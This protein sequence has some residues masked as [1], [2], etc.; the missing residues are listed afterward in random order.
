L[1]FVTDVTILQIMA[2]KKTTYG[3]LFPVGIRWTDTMKGFNGTPK[4]TKTKPAGS[5]RVKPMPAGGDTMKK[6]KGSK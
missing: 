1:T 2:A 5:K 6:G 4:P 3:A